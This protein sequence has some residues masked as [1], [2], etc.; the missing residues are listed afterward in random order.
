MELYLPETK[1]YLRLLEYF[2]K[3][4]GGDNFPCACQESSF[5]LYT[6]LQSKGI[7]CEIKA[8]Y[9]ED[10]VL[11]HDSLHFWVET[12]ENI[13]DGSAVQFEMPDYNK[14]YTYSEIAEL[15]ELDKCSMVYEKDDKRYKN[16][17]IAYIPD[18]LGAFAQFLIGQKYDNMMMMT[19]FA[20]LNLYQGCKEDFVK[21]MLSSFYKIDKECE[22]I[23]LEDFIKKCSGYNSLNNL[24]VEDYVVEY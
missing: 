10:P 22:D 7:E 1:N 24:K 16:G 15:V 12:K 8:G 2:A 20:T 18:R 19:T 5:L 3:R 6:W 21:S 13:I 17:V 23:S 14:S 4:L 9:Y 11:K